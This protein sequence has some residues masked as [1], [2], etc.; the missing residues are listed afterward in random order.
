VHTARYTVRLQIQIV[1]KIHYT[2]L[3]IRNVAKPKGFANG[4]TPSLESDCQTHGSLLIGTTVGEIFKDR[5][6]KSPG[7]N[8]ERNPHNARSTRW[9]LP[10]HL[11][12]PSRNQPSGCTFRAFPSRSLPLVVKGTSTENMGY[13]QTSRGQGDL[14][15]RRSILGVRSGS[16]TRQREARVYLEYTGTSPC[17]QAHQL[18]V[19]PP[20]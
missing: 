15:R 2:T 4:F 7:R 6:R 13:L 20:T 5:K 8:A 1:A 12:P 17:E 3:R 16:H 18:S 19:P 10:R 11:S 9:L 14:L